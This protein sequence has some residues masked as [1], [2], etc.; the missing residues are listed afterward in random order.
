MVDYFYRAYALDP[1][2]P[3]INLSLALAY[4]HYAMN[5]QSENRHYLIVQGLSFLYSYYDLQ[6]ES[7]SATERQEC[8][9]NVGRAYHMIGLTNLAIPYYERCLDICEEARKNDGKNDEE[10]DVED[11]GIEAAIA[12]QGLWAANGQMELAQK[13]TEKWLVL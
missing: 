5:R 9:F 11:Y 10:G 1:R 4:L 13:I 12:L 2:H 8:E 6:R 3:L 7:H